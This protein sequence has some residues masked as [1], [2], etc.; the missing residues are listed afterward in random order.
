MFDFKYRTVTKTHIPKRH[1]DFEN[2]IIAP[3]GGDNTADRI[4]GERNPQ[5]MITETQ[6]LGTGTNPADALPKLGAKT[7]ASEAAVSYSIR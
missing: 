5:P 1:L 6:T 3:G 7:L 4:Y 2:P